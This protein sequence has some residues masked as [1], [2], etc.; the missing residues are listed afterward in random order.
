MRM[1]QPLQ[2]PW[3]P[4]VLVTI[5][6]LIAP[7]RLLATPQEV[8]AAL[9][10]ADSMQMQNRWPE[11]IQAYSRTVDLAE[12]TFGANHRFLAAMLFKLGSANQ[13][14]GHFPEA[15]AAFRRS[16]AIYEAAGE[17]QA[18][19]EAANSLANLC[20]TLEK[21]EEA[22]SLYRRCLASFEKS[23]GK[24]S[25]AVAFV[26]N[27]WAQVHI[28]LAQYAEAEPLLRRG[29][30]ILEQKRGLDHAD[31]TGTL[32][33]WAD[34]KM[35]QGN[36]AQALAL[37]LRCVAIAE[38]QFG[39]DHIEVARFL[40]NLGG[41]YA[42]AGQYA[43]AKATHERVLK[44]LESKLGAKH[45]D[46][47][48]SLQN[49]AIA[50][51]DLK[52]YDESLKAYERCLSIKEAVYGKDHLEVA[53]VMHNMAATYAA[54]K[55]YPQAES[56]YLQSFKIREA[57]LPENHPDL[58][59][60]LENLGA[61]RVR[62]KDY[63]AAES[64]YRRAL[65]ILETTLGTDHPDVARPLN[66][67]AWIHASRKQWDEVAAEADRSR[68]IV[69]RHAALVLPML[70]EREQLTFIENIDRR[71]LH[72]A[73][74]L[75]WA[76]VQNGAL[77]ALTASWLANGKAVAQETL[78]QRAA[79]GRD[80][81]NPQLTDLVKQLSAA[82]KQ[83]ANLTNAPPKPGQEA[84]HR[85]ELT[86]LAAL[87]QS[88]AKQLAAAGGTVAPA[89]WIELDDIRKAIPR[90][91]LL[92]D[93]IRFKPVAFG[94][95][96]EEN[97]ARP[98]HY[99]AWLTPPPGPE[100][101]RIVDLGESEPIDRAVTVA[102]IAM[103]D[104]IGTGQEKSLI[105][106]KGEPE[107]EKKFQEAYREASKLI[108]APLAE[109]LKDRKELIVSPDASLWLIPWGALP[110]E[111]GH[112]AI[113][114]WNIRYVVTARD[115]VK[116]SDAVTK[117]GLPRIF[118]NPNY[119]LAASEIPTALAAALAPTS[120]TPGKFNSVPDAAQLAGLDRG[121][122]S[123]QMFGQARPLPGSAA[124]AAAIEPKLTAYA[125]RPKSYTGDQALEGVFKLLSPPKVL[126]LSTHGFFL[127][128]RELKKDA[129]VDDDGRVLENPLL[130]CGLLLAGFNNRDQIA[131]K[132]L[133]DGILT[134]MEI[135][136]VNL[137]GTELVVLSA[138][139]TG[140]G[141]VRNGEGVAGLRQAFQ[142]AGA[143]AVVSTLWEIPDTQ[144]SRL[145][146]DFFG[147]LSDG[148]SKSDALR[149]A[150]LT[151]IKTRR[152]KNGAA[153]PF[154]WAAFTLTGN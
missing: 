58:A 8:V 16:L 70:G 14:G 89:A 71:M 79:L 78:V 63:D 66:G 83:L 25:P 59:H 37:Q 119:D 91:G 99:A 135:V 5:V 136:G 39:K 86:R 69:R 151:M 146:N 105:Q 141:E 138:C 134:G 43:D 10:Q 139:E 94:A 111:G 4:L 112:Y 9:E 57:K 84:A 7:V 110:I 27:N 100:Q 97:E 137:R 46:V 23:R 38:K 41:I 3:A 88:L 26:L 102:R 133:D 116:S 19:A 109:H 126:V 1:P 145:M 77:T 123:M 65:V 90:H 12:R 98:F 142:L 2:I 6:Q 20:V 120:L 92:V 21:R 56:L 45:P 54:L 129:L 76:N 75:G 44:I 107:A 113:E 140:L 51:C 154:F 114:R 52:Q 93:L 108:L 13:S 73:L 144:S 104:A 31:L 74:T 11:A 147:N 85:A 103:Q 64:L 22:I 95:S 55:R 148:Q 80:S 122:R 29:L 124:E 121:T 47:A 36:D 40:N 72:G 149:G 28:A 82:R 115:L 143:R 87:E 32:N 17:P 33:T 35:R 96:E 101:V 131:D 81:A 153:H 130:R 152:E 50:C 106:Q 150:Q 62:Q 118:A 53:L 49:L 128:D 60:S 18:I 42:D 34:L 127:P 30:A 68:H 15:E 132:N 125:G 67:L 61:L 117:V 24:D 48:R